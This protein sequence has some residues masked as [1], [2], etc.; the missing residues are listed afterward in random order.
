MRKLFNTLL[1]LLVF[2]SCSSPKYAYYFDHYDYNAGKKKK[3]EELSA[4][5][6]LAIDESTLSASIAEEPIVVVDEK[7]TTVSEEKVAQAKAELAN[8]F[9]TM[10]KAEKKEFKREIKAEVKK[11][12]KEK[13]DD[14]AMQKAR[15]E[16]DMRYAAIFGA[17]GVVLLIIG[18]DVL[19]ILGAV[20]L[21]IGL[22][23]F[24]KWLSRQ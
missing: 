19:S 12:L 20:A 13:K 3:A 17:I 6:P 16:H 2:A 10:T 21:L 8:K 14:D 1:A 22:Y 9:S 15:L 7:N 5:S 11:A 23:F 4:T 24:I 18:G